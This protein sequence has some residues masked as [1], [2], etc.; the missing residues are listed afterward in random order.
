MVAKDPNAAPATLI[1]GEEAWK[2]VCGDGADKDMLFVVE[3]FCHWCGPSEAI[4]ST[5]KR[6]VMDYNGRKLKFLNMEA[7]EEIPE[8][9]KFISTSRPHFLFFKDGEQ[10]DTVEGV[11]APLLE[12]HIADQIP[13]GVYASPPPP[14]ADARA[15]ASFPIAHP[16]PDAVR[17]FASATPTLC[18]TSVCVPRRRLENADAEAGDEE[19]ED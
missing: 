19:E 15:R 8:L 16:H 4:V 14:P 10:L 17:L 18:V 3:V 2:K 13:E 7:T 12:K 11:N 5:L 9:A 6:L 1:E